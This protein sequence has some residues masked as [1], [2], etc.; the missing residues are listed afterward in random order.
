MPDLVA[1]LNRI[2]RYSMDTVENLLQQLHTTP[3]ARFPQHPEANPASDEHTMLRHVVADS[4]DDAG[5]S[6]ESAL[7]RDNGQHVVVAD[8]RVR[9]GRVE[10]NRIREAYNKAHFLHDRTDAGLPY[11]D[12]QTDFSRP[13]EAHV[14]VRQ[15]YPTPGRRENDVLVHRGRLGNFLADQIERDAAADKGPTT[16]FNL[17][18]E[19]E[20]KAA[21]ATLRHTSTDEVDPAHLSEH[22]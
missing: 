12:W 15:Q 1:S 3:E 8:G 6:S 9:A 11:M 22:E 18:S 13:E 20:R 2:L 17:A 21:L 14:L 16:V 4:L 5:R 10:R 19:G 7:L